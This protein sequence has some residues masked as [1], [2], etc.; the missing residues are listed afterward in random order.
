MNLCLG[1]SKK[2]ASNSNKEEL[3][4]QKSY[5]LIAPTT[6]ASSSKVQN[7]KAHD[8]EVP[9]VSTTALALEDFIYSRLTTHDDC[10]VHTNNKSNTDTNNF[11]GGNNI[12]EE[13]EEYNPVQIF[14]SDDAHLLHCRP[15]LSNDDG[16]EPA[17]TIFGISERMIG[18]NDSNISIPVAL[19]V[20]EPNFKTINSGSSSN[21]H[22]KQMMMHLF[23]DGCCCHHPKGDWARQ[24]IRSKAQHT[25]NGS[26]V[27]SFSENVNVM[28]VDLTKMQNLRRRTN[29]QSDSDET[30]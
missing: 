16:E 5:P 24:D 13:E 7:N 20:C 29:V 2:R 28:I 19:T 26:N 18:Q 15:L 27:Q 11:L 9:I 6:N 14:V 23:K 25:N 12:D 4:Y 17:S 1:I 3:Q 30:S 8:V 10:N 21:Q 22:D